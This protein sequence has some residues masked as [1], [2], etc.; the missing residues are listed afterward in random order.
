MALAK[1]NAPNGATV[2][3]DSD[4]VENL[5]NQGFT[6]PSEPKREPAKKAASSSTTKKN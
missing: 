2:W 5:L 3:V 4:R 6:K 1:L